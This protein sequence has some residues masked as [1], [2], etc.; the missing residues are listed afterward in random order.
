M[1][2]MTY[3][4]SIDYG[5]MCK[6]G[7]NAPRQI[8]LGDSGNSNYTLEQILA[9]RK[10]FETIHKANEIETQIPAHFEGK[11]FVPKRINKQGT[12]TRRLSRLTMKF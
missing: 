4:T 5:L 6:I 11:L 3:L 10:M 8:L 12:V 7:S 2:N 1:I 9:F